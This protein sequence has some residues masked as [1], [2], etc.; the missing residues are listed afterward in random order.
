[1]KIKKILIMWI[2]LVAS[3]FF[4][5]LKCLA[6]S[7]NEEFI[8]SDFKIM[9]Y[10]SGGGKTEYGINDESGEEQKIQNIDAEKY[11]LPSNLYYYNDDIRLRIRYEKNAKEIKDCKLVNYKTGEII[12]DTSEEN[13][14]K[15]FNI[16]YGKNIIEKEW[17]AEID[18]S[19]FEENQIYK[20]TA[21]E[22]S[23]FPKIKNDLKKNCIVYLKEC[24][25]E[26]DSKVYEKNIYTGKQLSSNV[27]SISIHE[28][29][30]GDS[31]N[32]S[33]RI[34]ENEELLKMIS[35][36]EIIYLDNY[37]TGDK[38]NYN[39]FE[40]Y[41]YNNTQ[42]DITIRV[43]NAVSGVEILNEAVTI[44]KNQ[45]YGFDWMIDS[46]VIEKIDNDGSIENNTTETI[47]KTEYTKI[48]TTETTSK[49]E[50]VKNN[51][52]STTAKTE[53]PKAGIN[54]IIYTTMAI[55]GIAV[56][57]FIILNKKYK[58]IK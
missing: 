40:K 43:K 14:N 51:S 4:G 45:I 52:D 39:N 11:D 31:F 5:N 30:L 27:P 2:I 19:N 9:S 46:A 32:I 55:V 23:Q 57:T 28:Y 38:L 33:Y 24:V 25:K 48:P 7:E 1:M 12:E 54:T 6:D 50:T 18:L 29:N 42:N 56:A 53:L 21:K 47:T 8:T 10:V 3:I 15:L 49:T 34:V 16:E 37:K 35:K 41:I 17:I 58:D 26:Y 20:F 36:N 13:I 22:K 44:E